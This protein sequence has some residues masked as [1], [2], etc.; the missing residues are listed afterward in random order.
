MT[1]RIANDSY[2]LW[3]QSVGKQR[4]M[5][6]WFK[7]GKVYSTLQLA[8]EGKRRWSQFPR[9]TK[10]CW[11]NLIQKGK[12]ERA[13]GTKLKSMAVYS[14]FLTPEGKEKVGIQYPDISK[15]ELDK[16]TILIDHSLR[17]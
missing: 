16:Y 11:S 10:R 13:K 17:S 3:F 1:T 4:I 8:A 5:E 2:F 14:L 6:H 15:E 9:I 7:E 12:L